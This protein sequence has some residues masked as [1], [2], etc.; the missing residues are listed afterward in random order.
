[1]LQLILNWN[2][3]WEYDFWWREKYNI[4]FNSLE[5]REV[6][7]IDIKWDWAEKRL[8]EREQKEFEKRRQAELQYLKDGKWLKESEVQTKKEEKL[9]DKI[10][11]DSIIK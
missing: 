3:K 4:A 5:H 6:S 1:M 9:L 11:L 10:S 8:A 2:R 7:Q